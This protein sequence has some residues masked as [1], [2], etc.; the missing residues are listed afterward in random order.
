MMTASFRFFVLGLIGLTS[1]GAGGCSKAP[2]ENPDM[3]PPTV[4]VS[5]PV[6]RPVTDYAEFTGRTA[7]IESVKLRARVWGHLEKIKFTEGADVK[8]DQVL[9]V[10]DQRHYKAAYARAEADLSQSQA[11]L[12]RFLRD[13]KRYKALEEKNAISQEDLDKNDG[14]V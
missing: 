6:V 14:E 7:A 12:D 1:I 11:R 13:Q 4:K 3:P 8:K 5:E 2:G 9:F 10:I